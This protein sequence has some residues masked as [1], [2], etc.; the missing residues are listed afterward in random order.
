MCRERKFGPDRSAKHKDPV[1]GNG[2]A[3]SSSPTGKAMPARGKTRGKTH[4]SAQ[5]DPTRRAVDAPAGETSVLD[6]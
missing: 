2:E 5:V 3:E 1:A 4:V 6:S